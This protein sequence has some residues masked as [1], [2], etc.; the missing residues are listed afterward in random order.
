MR[1][2]SPKYSLLPP[3]LAK[4][5]G[6]SQPSN[7]R[8]LTNSFFLCRIVEFASAEDAQRAVRELSE[9]AML[10]RPVF[11]R[12]V[13]THYCVFEVSTDIGLGS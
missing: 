8:I 12:E 7:C 13:R 3:A 6:E 10:G 1:F 9:Q 4:D 11:I 5:A 2:S